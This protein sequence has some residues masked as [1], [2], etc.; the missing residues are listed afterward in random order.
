M[1]VCVCARTKRRPS[2]ARAAR[3]RRACGAH[4]QRASGA[5]ERRARAARE[6]CA[7]DAEREIVRRRVVSTN[8]GGLKQCGASLGQAR[9]GSPTRLRMC[10]PNAVVVRPHLG[11]GRPS[12]GARPPFAGFGHILGGA[13]LQPQAHVRRVN[14]GVKPGCLSCGSSHMRILHA[15]KISKTRTTTSMA[16]RVCAHTSMTIRSKSFQ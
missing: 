2:A 13:D 12:L 11:N 6:L 5:H 15:T 3:L 4:E 8:L 10:R 14:C 1:H 16:N 7:S 9:S